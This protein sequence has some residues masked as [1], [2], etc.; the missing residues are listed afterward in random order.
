MIS[1]IKEGLLALIYPVRAVCQGCSSEAGHEQGWLCEECRE[2]LAK[3]WVGASAAPGECH[4]EGAA[5]AY[6]YSG[7]AGGIVRNMKYYG[8]H[9]LGEM[10]ARDMVR[11]L[12][13]LEP[14]YADMVVPVPMH[15]LRK[16]LRGYNQAEV[17]AENVARIKGIE[18]I[19][20]LRRSRNT[21]QQARLT[22]E[23]RRHN[24][25]SAITVDGDVAGKTILLVDDV[26][27]TGATA[28]ACEQ[29]L[30]NAGAKHVFLVCYALAKE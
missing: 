11:A 26:C 27:T 23:E 30:R 2:K 9:R 4:V 14:I 6:Y 1:K 19:C 7:P 25:R 12:D 21:R 13:P 5:F 22:G 20:A 3:A 18:M 24:L 10:M 28:A 16:H 29:A 8:V 17:L 15:H